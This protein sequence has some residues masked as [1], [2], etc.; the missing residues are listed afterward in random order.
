MPST[1]RQMLQLKPSPGSHRVALRAAIS[2]GV[3][4]LVLLAVGRPQWTIYASFGAFT[5]LYGRHSA[6][7]VRL[8][9]QSCAAVCLTAAVLT[10]VVVGMWPDA[11]VL[12]VAVAGVIAATGTMIASALSYH[13][14]GP[15][16]FLFAY[17]AVG[18]LPHRWSDL[19][20]AAA[21][22]GAAALF[23]VAVGV[24]GVVRDPRGVRGALDLAERLPLDRRMTWQPAWMALAVVTSGA[25][26]L[27]LPF[28]HAYWAMISAVAPLGMPHVT[29]Q[30]QR[31]IQRAIGTLVGLAPAALLLGLHL[32]PWAA[33][34]VVMVLQFTTE[35]MIG[36][37]YAYAMLSITPM[38]LLMGQLGHAQPM[39]PLLRDRGAETAVGS[40]VGIAVVLVGWAIRRR[41]RE[42]VVERLRELEAATGRRV[43]A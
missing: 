39:G 42:R 17:G 34:L 25:L 21:V 23:A 32:P 36:R 33:A 16:F 19:P 3:P 4:V 29:Q 41:R 28:G 24:A 15:I 37:N 18:S 22:T 43:G 38:A 35:W 12:H 1:V 7:L 10:G 8:Q 30:V 13:P 5:S 40:L 27:L 26:A 11:A 2:V 6:H 14:P 31:G 20:V 9:M